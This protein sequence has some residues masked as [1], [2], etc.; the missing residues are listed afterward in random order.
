M[1][2]IKIEGFAGPDR[3]EVTT[4]DIHIKEDVISAIDEVN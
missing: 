1:Q 4:D 3:K 2:I